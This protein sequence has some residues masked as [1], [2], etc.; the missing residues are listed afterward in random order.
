MNITAIQTFLAVHRL[1]A[2]NRAAATLNVT[3]STI[4]ARLDTL[5]DAFGAPLLTRSRKG[6]ALTKAGWSFLAE[7]EMIEAAWL[8]AQ[9]R[10]NLPKGS[11]GLLSF[12]CDAALWRHL[13]QD[14]LAAQRAS[15]PGLTV[16]AWPG[17][18]AELAHWLSTAL[19]D[20]ALSTAPI[21]GDGL[22]T[23]PYANDSIHQVATQPRQ[24]RSWHRD[25]VFV[26]HGPAFRRW[27]GET[28]RAAKT[29]PLSFGAPDWA[30]THLLEHGGSAYLPR[31]MTA[32]LLGDKLFEVRGA[33]AFTRETHLTVRRQSAS[34]LA[35]R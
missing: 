32:P 24:A 25:Y 29:A 18:Q 35:G 10:I 7:A 31:R 2:L 14:W 30:L 16:E 3:Q 1:G 33:A 13:G 8:R 4:T 22:I 9:Q 23:Q 12:G 6:A 21:H 11:A 26:D 5:D 28:W 34:L 15:S 19:I 27:H 17:G 20:V